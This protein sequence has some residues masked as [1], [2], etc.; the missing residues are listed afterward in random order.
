MV[1]AGWDL[2]GL[3]QMRRRIEANSAE[4]VCFHEAGHA[5]VAQGVGAKPVEM[6]LYRVKGQSFGRARIERNEDQAQHICLGGFAAEIV[7]YRA[8][9]TTLNGAPLATEKAL[10]DIAYANASDDYDRF[11]RL[12]QGLSAAKVTGLDRTARDK[13]FIKGADDLAQQM[14]LGELTQIADL[15]LDCGFLDE[16]AI[17]NPSKI[18][19]LGRW[20]LK[21]RCFFRQF[22][23]EARPEF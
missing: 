22:K 18:S 21:L 16:A 13:I 17:A 14:G 9:I 2:E 3:Q 20:K 5:L 23:K 19:R 8:K 4:Y 1:V 7:L 6:H 15:L 12:Q 11:W 10:I